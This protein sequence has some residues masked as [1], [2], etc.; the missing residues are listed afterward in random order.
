MKTYYG[1]KIRDVYQTA[2][3]RRPRGDNKTR[4]KPDWVIMGLGDGAKNCCYQARRAGETGVRGIVRK[5][6][7]S[8]PTPVS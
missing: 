4:P 6:G 2:T 1:L 3:G 7:E 8:K 5:R